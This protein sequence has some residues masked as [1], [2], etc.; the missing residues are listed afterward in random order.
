MSGIRE[1]K[2]TGARRTYLGISRG[3][4]RKTDDA[5]KMQEVE[6]EVYKGEIHP[7]A[8]HWHPYGF[9][10][11]PKGPDGGKYAE[12]LIAYPSGSRSHPVVIAVADRR[13]RPKNLKEG[14]TVLHDSSGQTIH[15]TEDGIV[16]TSA[17]KLTIKVGGTSVVVTP[18]KVLLGGDAATKRVKLED[19]SNATKVYAL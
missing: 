6:V 9:T 16:I 12:A 3:V 18:E 19:G 2:A 13:H 10:S 1:T 14:E 5:K 15:F 17:K 7:S 4:I 11:R 8:E